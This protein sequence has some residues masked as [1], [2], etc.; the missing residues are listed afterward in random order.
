M[1]CSSLTSI[2]IPNSVTSIAT[3]AFYYCTNLASVTIPNSVTSIRN[4]VFVGC[5]SLKN[6]NFKGT[7]ND[8]NNIIK[9]STWK[10]NSAIVT[11]TCTDGTITL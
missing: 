9:D 7:M 5:S 2:T 11:I 8:W 1:G 10:E 4:S 6:I 3:C